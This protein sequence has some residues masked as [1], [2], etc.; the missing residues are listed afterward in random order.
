MRSHNS[1][2]TRHARA[3]SRS[4]PSMV[5]MSRTLGSPKC[6]RFRPKARALPFA[7]RGPGDGRCRSDGAQPAPA[8]RSVEPRLGRVGKPGARRAFEIL[9]PV[10]AS[11]P[12]TLNRDG[13][14]TGPAARLGCLKICLSRRI[15]PRVTALE[16]RVR[17]GPSTG[18][19]RIHRRVRQPANDYS[20]AVQRCLSADKPVRGMN[21][22]SPDWGIR[23]QPLPANSL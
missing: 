12:M 13:P 9:L 15:A 17:P 18:H 22:A 20:S 14:L 6:F 19:P 3:S 21:R 5:S 8:E 2:A 4:S 1:R 16:R 7:R 10:F 23:R 11:L